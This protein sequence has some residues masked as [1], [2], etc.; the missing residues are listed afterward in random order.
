MR[1][2]TLHKVRLTVQLAYQRNLLSSGNAEASVG[3]QSRR[4]SCYKALQPSIV[5]GSGMPKHEFVAFDTEH[6]LCHQSMFKEHNL[7][8]WML[9]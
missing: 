5:F 2:N 6:T 4:L 1:L 8:L 9:R 3:Q 7:L